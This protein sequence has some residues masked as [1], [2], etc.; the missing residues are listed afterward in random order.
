MTDTMI[1]LSDLPNEDKY[2]SYGAEACAVAMI[3]Y[4]L[5]YKV[6]PVFRPNE[7]T[8]EELKVEVEKGPFAF[9]PPMGEEQQQYGEVRGRI[10][11]AWQKLEKEYA[12][13]F[14]QQ[15][16]LGA[17]AEKMDMGKILDRVYDLM[18]EGYGVYPY[19][20]GEKYGF[21]LA[22]GRDTNTPLPARFV[23]GESKPDGAMSQFL[24]G[25]E[26]SLKDE[27]GVIFTIDYTMLHTLHVAFQSDV[28][29]FFNKDARTD[30][31][32]KYFA[33]F[34]PLHLNFE[35]VREHY[36]ALN[37]DMLLENRALRRHP[38]MLEALKSFHNIS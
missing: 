33:L 9:A 23:Y 36:H 17:I 3:K 10:G 31:R 22:D 19:C 15:A 14:I 38:D 16:N 13:R 34:S 25:L 7:G 12:L 27:V 1:D 5:N 26:E 21:V 6:N 18:E 35:A 32:M 29:T 8:E 2:V 11:R 28:L 20:A 37:H 30:Q 4:C 24:P